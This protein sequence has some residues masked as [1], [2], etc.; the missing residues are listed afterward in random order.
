MLPQI[1]DLSREYFN[2][3]EFSV[4]VRDASSFCKLDEFTQE[5]VEKG[6]LIRWQKK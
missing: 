1:Y 5:E 4:C 6:L 3:W 2:H